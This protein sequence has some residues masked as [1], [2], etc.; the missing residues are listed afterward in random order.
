[1]PK[2]KDR[3]A[4]RIK[5]RQVRRATRQSDKREYEKIAREVRSRM[6]GLERGRVDYWAYQSLKKK[7]RDI[8]QCCY[9]FL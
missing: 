5:A 8:F 2:K 7:N 1:M 9:T 4:K 3:K 6:R